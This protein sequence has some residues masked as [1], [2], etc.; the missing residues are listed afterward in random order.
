MTKT[1]LMEKIRN[2]SVWKRHEQRA[3]HKPL[4]ILLSLGRLQS[5]QLRMALF[6]E[7]EGKLT[8]LLED[9]GPSR[10]SYHPEEPFCRLQTDDIWELSIDL[11]SGS[12]SKTTLR[13]QRVLGGF[14]ESVFRL[15]LE[16]DLLID[17]VA[18]YLLQEHFQPTLHE[19]ILTEVG[20]D[21]NLVADVNDARLRKRKRD[22]EFRHRVLQAY[23]YRCAICNFDVRLGQKS[24]ALE[25]AHIQWFNHDG[26]DIVNNGAALC[27]MHHKLLDKGAIALSDDLR[28]LVSE[29]VNGYAGLD[30]W[31]LSFDGKPINKPRA[32]EYTI[33][34]EFTQWHIR[35]VFKGKYSVKSF[36]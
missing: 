12:L 20:L 6:S 23:N 33:K 2:L 3:P 5:N 30:E 13:N 26:P 32:S 10:K 11:P 14:T 27:S 9:F 36:T 15:L 31:V 21:I 8:S 4:L 22:P 18:T 16:D 25:A 19:D 35:E 29:N 34:P 28:V 17:Q 1:E 7:I 24:I